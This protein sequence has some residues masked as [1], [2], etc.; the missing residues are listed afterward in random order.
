MTTTSY[1][2]TISI[3]QTFQAGAWRLHR[4]AAS[5]RV[6]HLANAGK[7]GKKCDDFWLWRSGLHDSSALDGVALRLACLAVDGIGLNEM[8]VEIEV[9][10]GDCGATMERRWCRG[11]DVSPGG[12][13]P[14]RIVGAHV[15]VIAEYDS[16]SVL[17]I[18][19]TNNEP[20]MIPMKNKDRK[21]F[22]A[23]AKKNEEALKTMRFNDVMRA[24]REA[25]IGYHYYCAVD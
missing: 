16:W 9:A 8:A 14:I 13:Q 3:G 7:R 1:P 25:G 10:S 17:D 20:T 18:V 12:F 21:V 4:F 23:W 11:I 2:E 19:D 5:V 22:Y 24:L 15:R 6:T